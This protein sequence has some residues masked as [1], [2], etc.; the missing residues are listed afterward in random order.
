MT[1]T[2]DRNYVSESLNKIRGMIKETT[3]EQKSRSVD[4]HRK[5]FELMEEEKDN[6]VQLRGFGREA[7]KKVVDINK[8]RARKTML[9]KNVKTI[10]IVN[11]EQSKKNC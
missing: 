1:Q 9:T 6:V 5:L 7:D 4:L 2:D 11:V 10:T 8:V 3:D